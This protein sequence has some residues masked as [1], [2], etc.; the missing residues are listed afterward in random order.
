MDLLVNAAS[1]LS[2][3]PRKKR[4]RPPMPNSPSVPKK[5]KLEFNANQADSSVVPITSPKIAEEAFKQFNAIPSAVVR[6]WCIR[7]FFTSA[8]DEDYFRDNEFIAC[9]HILGM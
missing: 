8:I 2:E 3:S 1:F 4:E 7:E 9:L 5:Y 6:A